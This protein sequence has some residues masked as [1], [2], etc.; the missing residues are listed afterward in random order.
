MVCA[1]AERLKIEWFHGI[2]LFLESEVGQSFLNDTLGDVLDRDEVDHK[3]FLMLIESA[4]PLEGLKWD[5]EQHL[6]NWHSQQR[7]TARRL[8]LDGRFARGDLW[9]QR[10]W[11]K[12]FNELSEAAKD[13]VI[14][15]MAFIEEKKA[16]LEDEIANERQTPLMPVSE[17]DLKECVRPSAMKTLP[18]EEDPS[19]MDRVRRYVDELG[20]DADFS[21]FEGLEER[22]PDPK[23][24]RTIYPPPSVP[25]GDPDGD[26]V[27][28]ANQAPSI[29]PKK[30]DTPSISI[31]H[32]E[33]DPEELLGS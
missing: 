8:F 30:D 28:P 31:S 6:C 4:I 1:E 22:K 25:P 5:E 29:I 33:I 18:F 21:A 3:V 20:A 9:D 2:T 11:E 16:E 10:A 7:S 32:E 13:A 26:V 17:E 12:R 27:I 15:I 19:A 24:P 23:R 14:V